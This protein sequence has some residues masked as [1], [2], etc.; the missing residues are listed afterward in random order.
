[1]TLCDEPV[2]F[3]NQRRCWSEYE[4][5]RTDVVVDQRETLFC[6]LIGLVNVRLNHFD[7]FSD[8]QIF[9]RTKFK[10]IVLTIGYLWSSIISIYFLRH[11]W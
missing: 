4:S 10:A 8:Y 11:A 6:L 5:E 1:M 7:S 3:K 2:T 9:I